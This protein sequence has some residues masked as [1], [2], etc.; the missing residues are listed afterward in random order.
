MGD[1]RDKEASDCVDEVVIGGSLGRSQHLEGSC[2]RQ[3]DVKHTMMTVKMR[4]GYKGAMKRTM[5]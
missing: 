1:D 4:V 3:E 5:R 2:V